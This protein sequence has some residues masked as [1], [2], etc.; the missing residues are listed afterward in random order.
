MFCDAVRLTLVTGIAIGAIAMQAL[1]AQTKLKAYSVAEVEPI[2]GATLSPS[3][4][5]NIRKVIS[6]SHG[7]TLR[8]L[9]GKVFH[10][11]GS[12]APAKVAIVEWDS[13][14]DAKAF[15][16]S[17]TWTDFAPE[18]DKAQKTIRRYI[19]EVEP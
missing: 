2:A 8:T 17:K 3:Y 14:D 9:N 13:A 18:R 5:D 10:I 6:E 1:N 19:V 7:R 15:Y 12:P 11:E 4:L 16:K